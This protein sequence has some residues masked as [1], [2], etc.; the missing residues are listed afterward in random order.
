MAVG[1][2][3][4][5]GLVTGLLTG[6]QV[7]SACGLKVCVFLQ[8]K[9]LTVGQLI[10]LYSNLV[11]PAFQSLDKEIGGFSAAFITPVTGPWCNIGFTSSS[12]S[13]PS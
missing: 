2:P 1:G 7:F 4:G 9:T 13:K 5:R 11:S 10:K 12:I 3:K 8:A 6:I